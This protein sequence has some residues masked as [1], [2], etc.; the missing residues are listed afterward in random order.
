M[1]ELWVVGTPIGNLNDLSDRMREALTNCDLIA[2]EDTR[3]TMK[4]LSHLNIKKPLCS[5]HRHNEA[6]KADP[7]VQRMLEE[8]LNVCLTCDAG[9]PGISD[10][11]VFLVRAALAAGIRVIP[12]CGPSAVTAHLSACG[13]DAR[14]FAFYGFLPREKKA[15]TEKLLSVRESGVPVAVFYE[16]PH[17]IVAL[18]ETLCALFPQARLSVA[19]DLSKRYEKILTGDMETVLAALRGNENVEKGEYSVALDL[20]MLPEPV[21]TPEIPAEARLFLGMLDGLTLEE[22]AEQAQ[23][24]GAIPRNELYRAKL[25]IRDFLS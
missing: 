13:F 9:T 11:G 14:A 1:A 6:Q 21:K 10:P 25:R 8:D 23:K 2:A 17:R 18:C 20:S 19:C 7:I 12:I 3:V 22:A 16:S 15:L 24:E 4:L 5:C